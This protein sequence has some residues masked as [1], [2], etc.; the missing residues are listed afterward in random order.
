MSTIKSFEFKGDPVYFPIV[1]RSCLIID[2]LL[3]VNSSGADVANVCNEAALIAA[4]HTSSFIEMKH[5]EQAIERVIGG[6]FLRSLNLWFLRFVFHSLPY[7]LAS[8]NLCD[9]EPILPSISL[10]CYTYT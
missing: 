8:S 7:K 10:R 4:R 5:F 3:F 1:S 6:N 2:V 9:R